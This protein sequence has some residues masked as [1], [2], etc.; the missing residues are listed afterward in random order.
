MINKHWFEWTA[1]RFYHRDHKE[2][3][4]FDAIPWS[5][6]NSEAFAGLHSKY[7]CVIFDEA[8]ADRRCDLGGDRGRDD[9]APGHVVCVRQPDQEHRPLPGVLRQAGTPLVD[10]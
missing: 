5:E 8:S 9:H 10:A 2:T 1:T 3:W 4:G 7:V 6:H